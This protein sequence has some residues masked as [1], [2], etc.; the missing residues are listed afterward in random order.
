[1]TVRLSRDGPL[2]PTGKIE[3]QPWIT[4]PETV[5]VMEALTANGEEARFI[6]GCVRDA[7]LKRPIRDIDIA[8]SAPPKRVMERLETA[9]IRVIPTGLEHGTVTAVVNKVQFEITTLRIDVETDGRRARVLFTDDWVA[10][11]AR[12]DFT[13]NTLSCSL[14]GDVFDPFGGLDDLAQAL[15]RFVGNP[16]TRVEEDLLRI[17]RFFRLYADYG[18][19]PPHAESLAA[20]RAQAHRLGE[21]SGERLRGE[22]FRILLAP[23]PAD[24]ISLMRGE[25]ILEHFLPEAENIGRLRML[26]WLETTAIKVPR[27]EPAAD[28]RL[29]A[30]LRVDEQGAKDIAH[31]FKLSNKRKDRLVRALKPGRSLSPRNTGHQIHRAL[32]HWGVESTRD[33][34]LLTWAGDKANDPADKSIKTGDWIELLEMIEHWEPKEFPLRG[35]DV[36]GQNIP[37]GSRIGRLLKSVETW[38]EEEDYRP[39]YKDCL[40]KL[41]SILLRSD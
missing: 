13:I 38:W 16:K 25:R 14:S 34:A 10:D 35:R 11:A 1:M 12:R 31:R 4:A 3:P 17:L 39:G 24:T 19:P 2:E 22:T 26:S 37:A 27:V 21:L 20:C 30:L 23:N 6:G 32:Q 28:R 40:K 36:L 5:A 18:K 41:N 9:G 33:V 8:T 29:A 7:V 15:V